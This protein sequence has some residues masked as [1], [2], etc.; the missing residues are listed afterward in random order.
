[1]SKMTLFF[2]HGMGNQAGGW[3]TAAVKALSESRKA[4][5]GNNDFATAYTIVPLNYQSYFDAYWAEYNSRAEGLSAISIGNAAPDLMKKVIGIAQQGVDETDPWIS[6]WADVILYLGT[7]LG[8]QIR[9][10]IWDDIAKALAGSGTPRWGVIAHSLGTRVIHDV[11][12]REYSDDTG[13]TINVFGKPRLLA[14]VSNIIRLSSF[15]EDHLKQGSAVY[16][17]QELGEGACWRYANI[18]HPLDPLARIR[19]FRIKRYPV[20]A[21]AEGA[22][23]VRAKATDV[24]GDIK[25]VHSLAHYLKIPEVAACL[26]NG[27]EWLYDSDPGPIDDVM[28]AQYRQQYEATTLVGS[29]KD[30]LEKIEDLDLND[31][32]NWKAIKDILEDL[33]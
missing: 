19:Q 30:K 2:I 4:M 24:V 13:S 27:M 15:S 28:V 31:L 22:Q 26:I 11:L 1:M 10:H 32:D 23:G 9:A 18:W 25:D 20:L 16:P 14:M 8:G 6:H 17:S 5:I 12:Q 33:L 29:W 21:Q 3:E 7:E